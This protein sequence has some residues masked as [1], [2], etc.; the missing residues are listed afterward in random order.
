MK[1]IYSEVTDPITGEITILADLGNGKFLSIPTDPANSDYQ[2]YL[3]PSE[4][5]E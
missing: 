4:V 3:N 1:P 5:N 2:E